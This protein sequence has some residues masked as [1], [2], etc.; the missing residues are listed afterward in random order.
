MAEKGYNL[1]LFVDA[2]HILTFEILKK[3]FFFYFTEVELIYNVVNFCCK[4]I[5]LHTYIN[6]VT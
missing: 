5:H 6:S 1:G 4:V 3:N 2:V